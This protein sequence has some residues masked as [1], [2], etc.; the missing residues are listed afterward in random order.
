[1]IQTVEDIEQMQTLTIYHSIGDEEHSFTNPEGITRDFLDP[2]RRINQLLNNLAFDY[3]YHEF[4]G[5][6]LWKNWQND[7]V[8]ALMFLYNDH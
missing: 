8:P 1:M 3:E 7:L 4:Q 5:N 6:H 2:N